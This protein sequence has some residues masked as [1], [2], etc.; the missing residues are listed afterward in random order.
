MTETPE[1]YQRLWNTDPSLVLSLYQTLV[2]PAVALADLQTGSG[3]YNKFNRWNT[4]DGIVHYIQNINTLGAAL[5]LAQGSVTAPPPFPDNFEA[6]PAPP[7]RA[8]RSI[9][10]CRS[11]CTCWS[12]RAST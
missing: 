8:R 1:Y 10:G 2:S 4:T 5:G 7:R 6:R 3:A 11:T 9:P 12:G